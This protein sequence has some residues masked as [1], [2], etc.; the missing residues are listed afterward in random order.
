M[1][2]NISVFPIIFRN[3]DAGWLQSQ[4]VAI[5]VVYVCVKPGRGNHNV[6][7]EF[8]LEPFPLEAEYSVSFPVSV[9]FQ[10]GN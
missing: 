6:H 10:Q 9:L 7:G 1:F 2:S 3:R 5:T 4:G 8:F